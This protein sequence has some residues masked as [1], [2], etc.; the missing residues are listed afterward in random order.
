MTSKLTVYTNAA[1]K[2]VSSI[3]RNL[4]HLLHGPRKARI[5][6]FAEKNVMHDVSYEQSRVDR[7]FLSWIES[8]KGQVS[9]HSSCG[10]FCANVKICFLFSIHIASFCSTLIWARIAL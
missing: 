9:S 3:G 8:V 1:C 6:I 5:G 4:K 7:K 2:S 10:G